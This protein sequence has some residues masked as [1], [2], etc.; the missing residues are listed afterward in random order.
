MIK[1]TAAIIRNGDTILLARRGPQKELAGYWEFPGGKVEPGESPEE[2]LTRELFEEF[3]VHVVVEKYFAESVFQYDHASIHLIAYHVYL[4]A[5]EMKLT[6]HD[7]IAWVKYKN[8]LDYRLPPADI[9]IAEQLQRGYNA[10]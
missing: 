4:P 6:A 9:P 5:D 3:G 7:A 1:V 8:L 10:L 2:C